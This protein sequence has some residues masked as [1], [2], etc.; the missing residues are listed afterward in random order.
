[1][2][3]GGAA[4]PIPVPVDVSVVAGAGN[5]NKLAITAPD[6]QTFINGGSTIID[7]RTGLIYRVL[8]RSADAP[9]TIVLDRPW[10][11]TVADSVW[12]VPPPVGGGKYPCIAVYQKVIGF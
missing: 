4:R 12:V 8:Q 5:E 11:G 3:P 1:M 6:E 9:E 2:Y 7:N 10:Q